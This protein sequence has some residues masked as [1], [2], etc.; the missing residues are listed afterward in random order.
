MNY[1]INRLKDLPLCLR[2]IREIHSILLKGVRGEE[3]RPGE[4]R[5]SQN[6]IGAKTLKNAI[7]V[8]PPPDRVMP[9]LDNFEKFL[10]SEESLPILIKTAL[11]HSQFELIH[12]FLDG[13]GRIGRLLITFYLCE[14]KILK[15]PLL[16]LSDYFRRYRTIYYDKLDAISKKDDIEGWIKFFLE[17]VIEISK[18]AVELSRKIIEL[19]EKDR[20]KISSL[21]KSTKPAN[22][23]LERLFSQ[24]FITTKNVM[25]ITHLAPPNANNLIKKFIALDILKEVGQKRRNRVFVYYNYLKLFLEE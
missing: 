5:K 15:K 3:N 2:L 23:L 7:Y 14:K 11:I 6:W 19:K 13:N 22:L 24:P 21:G 8:P 18:E 1:G 9:L 12:P 17:A 16:Y 25:E 10:H 4:F 20:D